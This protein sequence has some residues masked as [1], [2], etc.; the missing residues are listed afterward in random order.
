MKI[1]ALLASIVTIFIMNFMQAQK[2][3]VGTYNLRYDN[4]ADSG[5]LWV[6]RAP[7]VAALIR[8]HDFAYFW[9]SGRTKKSTG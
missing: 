6:N 3:I 5:N 8:F 1:K 7:F 2:L 9:H 4:P